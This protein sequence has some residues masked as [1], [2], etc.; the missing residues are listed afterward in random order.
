M[1]NRLRFIR[2]AMYTLKK[3]Y[4]TRIRLV[5]RVSISIDRETGVKTAVYQNHLAKAILLPN[6]SEREF[7]YPLAVIAASKAFV[8][9][10]LYNDNER[11]LIFDKASLRLVDGSYWQFNQDQWLVYNGKRYNIAEVTQFEES[12]SWLVRVKGGEGD[13]TEVVLDAGIADELAITQ[14]DVDVSIT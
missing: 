7:A 2:Q 6:L 3:R 11:Q 5:K 10:G 14:E 1:Q 8:H 12:E 13:E 4:G 9:G